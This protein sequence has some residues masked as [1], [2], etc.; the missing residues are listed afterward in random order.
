MHLKLDFFK[1]PLRKC[2][3]RKLLTYT[4]LISHFSLHLQRPAE[5]VRQQHKR[6][7]HPL[8]DQDEVEAAIDLRNLGINHRHVGGLRKIEQGKGKVQKLLKDIFNKETHQR[9]L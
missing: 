7:L 4:C 3:A 1:T 8:H 9:Q 2:S 6:L 5:H